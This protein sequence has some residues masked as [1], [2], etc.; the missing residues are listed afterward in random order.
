MFLVP[1]DPLFANLSNRRSTPWFPD[2]K[3]RSASEETLLAR[4]VA[5]EGPACGAGHV[6]DGRER[7]TR[8]LILPA[9]ELRGRGA[10]DGV[11]G[12][13]G[14]HD[15]AATRVARVGDDTLDPKVQVLVPRQPPK[16]QPATDGVLAPGSARPVLDRVLH[17]QCVQPALDLQ[18]P[19][20]GIRRET[21]REAIDPNLDPAA[22]AATAKR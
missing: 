21:L 2:G 14:G 6:D 18:G 15:P 5:D 1:I 17:E 3:P 4:Q 12:D 8:G 11:E 22:N 10:L 7:V 16:G 20:D 19:S 9:H 13:H